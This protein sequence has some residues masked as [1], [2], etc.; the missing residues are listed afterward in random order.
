MPDV[1][2][3]IQSQKEII[4]ATTC[5]LQNKELMEMIRKLSTAPLANPVLQLH[6]LEDLLPPNQLV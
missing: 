3:E 2:E 1:C 5:V 6:P 4:C